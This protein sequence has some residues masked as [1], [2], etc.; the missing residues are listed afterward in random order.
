MTVSH[1]P[2]GRHDVDLTVRLTEAPG[3]P[4]YTFRLAADGGTVSPASTLPD[5]AAA[6]EAVQRFGEDVFFPQ[7]GPPKMCTQQYGGPQVAVVTGWF[8]G[9]EVR[10]AFSRTDGCE[11]ARWRAMMPLLGGLA[12]ST[13]AI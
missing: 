4:E 10:S 3:A 8:L 5:P 7:P 1:N 6:L 12:G 2:D 13:G 11:I 9:R